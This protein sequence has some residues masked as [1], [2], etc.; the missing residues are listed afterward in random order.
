MT[1]QAKQGLGRREF[2]V[3]TSSTAIAAM[4]FG[5]DLMPSF[6][7]KSSASGRTFAIGYAE[8]DALD[9]AGDH[10][11]SNVM[12]AERVA[13]ADGAFVRKGVRFYVQSCNVASAGAT[14]SV[15]LQAL[16]AV[17]TGATVEKVP[18]GVFSYSRSK[19]RGSASNAVK[20]TMPLDDD[21]SIRLLL[22]VKP[23]AAATAAGDAVSRRGMLTA[24][25]GAALESGAEPQ[26]IDLS[27]RAGGDSTKLRR[28]YLIIAPLA[29]GQAAPQW[30]RLQLR[31]DKGLALFD[32]S[33]LD[34][35]RADFDYVILSVDY[36]EDVP[37]PERTPATRD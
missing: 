36:A 26:A 3:L 4:A 20:F 7:G 35:Q 27:L 25:Q 21:N 17:R 32:G 1:T 24:A 10:F 6:G 22:S 29:A 12:P 9:R 18:Y 14:G 34:V 30:D 5:Q 13:S 33:G 15:E 2:L 11:V 23:E 31:N 8:P 28:G 16:Y 19:G 37:R